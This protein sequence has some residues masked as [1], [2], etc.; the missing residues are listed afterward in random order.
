MRDVDVI[1]NILAALPL[2][3]VNARSRRKEHVSLKEVELGES[4]VARTDALGL[5]VIHLG[6]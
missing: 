1:L 3:N 6:F 4:L 5:D 2:V